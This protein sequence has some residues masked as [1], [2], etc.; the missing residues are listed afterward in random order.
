MIQGNVDELLLVGTID[1]S[2]FPKDVFITTKA[3]GSFDVTLP[4]DFTAAGERELNILTYQ[5][6]TSPVI[7]VTYPDVEQ[8]GW[9]ILTEAPVESV[10]VRKLNAGFEQSKKIQRMYIAN[11]LLILQLLLEM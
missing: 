11:A 10:W 1:E 9:V 4:K 7:D 2:S 3:D 5:G 8:T 6:T